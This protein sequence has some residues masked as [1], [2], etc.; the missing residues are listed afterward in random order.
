[1]TP[2]SQAPSARIIADYLR[3]KDAQVPL[4]YQRVFTADAR[5]VTIFHVPSPFGET[6]PQE[7]LPAITRTFRMMGAHNENIVT[8]VPVESLV[9]RDGILT[10]RWVVAM[11]RRDGTGGFSG[12]GSYRWTLDD[13]GTR[14]R[15]LEVTFEGMAALSNAEAPAVLSRLLDLSHPWC[16]QADLIEAI[17]DLPQ[18]ETLH[19]WL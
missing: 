4:L 18:L 11:T 17:S 5:F 8:V 12:W 9:Q 10:S 6:P 15:E 3:A 16:M 13:T 19:D 1:M 7:G 2:H 14:A